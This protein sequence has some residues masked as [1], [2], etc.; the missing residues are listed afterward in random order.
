[1]RYGG[2]QCRQSFT[3]FLNE[4][5][6]HQPS[7]VFYSKGSLF[8]LFPLLSQ[9]PQSKHSCMGGWAFPVRKIRVSVRTLTATYHSPPNHRGSRSLEHING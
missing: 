4:T 6:H 3:T 1:M 7:Q 5:V 9:F 2:Q 8:H